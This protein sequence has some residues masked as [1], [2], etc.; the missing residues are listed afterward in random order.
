MEVMR[1]NLTTAPCVVL[2]TVA[3]LMWCWLTLSPSG[4]ENRSRGLTSSSSPN[5]FER[6]SVF[7]R[8]WMGG[9][10]VLQNLDERF[11][12]R[13]LERVGMYVARSTCPPTSTVSAWLPALPVW[14]PTCSLQRGCPLTLTLNHESSILGL[15][16][17]W[18]EPWNQHHTSVVRCQVY[19]TRRWPTVFDSAAS[20]S[21]QQLVL[22]HRPLPN[23]W[24]E[25]LRLCLR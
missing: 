3:L 16:R 22:A 14:C 7:T 2:I 13:P 8:S 23:V 18:S 21:G 19:F 24:I 1:A 5:R 9:V 25:G 12:A 6:V 17:H 4:V 15:H 10:A 20:L 11:K